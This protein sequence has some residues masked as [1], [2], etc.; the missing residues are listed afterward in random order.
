MICKIH[1]LPNALFLSFCLHSN[2]FLNV[3]FLA[4]TFT[5][6]ILGPLVPLF[7]WIFGDVSFGFQSHSRFCFIYI[8]EANVMHIPWDPSLVLYLLHIAN[9]LM[10]SIVGCHFK[11]LAHLPAHFP[12]LSLKS[13]LGCVRTTQCHC[14]RLVWLYV[15]ILPIFCSGVLVL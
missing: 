10:G 7:C 14:A 8:V 5:C 4:D 6:L 15:L 1:K 9:L 2:L 12:S 13:N 11:M 3:F